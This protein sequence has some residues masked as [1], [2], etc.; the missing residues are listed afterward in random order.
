MNKKNLVLVIF[1]EDHQNS[2]IPNIF[3]RGG[4]ACNVGEQKP[5]YLPNP[6]HH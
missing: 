4:K 2:L 5:S 6:K 3:L 1:L